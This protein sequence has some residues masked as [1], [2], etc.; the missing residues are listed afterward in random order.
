MFEC[1][2]C[3]R[4]ILNE[5]KIFTINAN[6]KKCNPCVFRIN[7]P[8]QYLINE[9][10]RNSISTCLHEGSLKE[11]KVDSNFSETTENQLVLVLNCSGEVTFYVRI[12]CSSEHQDFMLQL[13]TKRI[14]KIYDNTY[15]FSKNDYIKLSKFINYNRK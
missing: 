13:C 7:Q 5:K 2:T 11:L 1:D 6:D 14:N 9:E 3:S 4:L 12:Q 10:L 8:E 15:D